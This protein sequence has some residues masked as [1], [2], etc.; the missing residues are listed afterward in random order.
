MEEIVE[1][2]NSSEYDIVKMIILLNKFTY[3]G[4]ET[5]LNYFIYKLLEKKMPEKIFIEIIEY[6]N[7]NN[8]DFTKVKHIEDLIEYIQEEGYINGSTILKT[9]YYIRNFNNEIEKFTY[10]LLG[11][12]CTLQQKV[13][14]L[15]LK[16]DEIDTID[17]N[18]KII[19]LY[20]IMTEA[21]EYILSFDK[22]TSYSKLNIEQQQ[23][24]ENIYKN[25]MINRL[26]LLKKYYGI[27]Y[28]LSINIKI[29]TVSDFIGMSYKDA[30]K[31]YFGCIKIIKKNMN[32]HLRLFHNYMKLR[33]L[34]NET[35]IQDIDQ[36]IDIDNDIDN[37]I[38]DDEDNNEMDVKYPDTI[39]ISDNNDDN[40]LKNVLT[41]FNDTR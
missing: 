26:I 20:K 33:K 9:F 37:D 32:N 1:A 36:D 24:N 19:Q 8:F 23:Q 38:D 10:I 17:F 31:Y 40:L 16:F 7:N 41:R 29:I 14:T 11:S 34:I 27:R 39:I 6:I 4:M 18:N 5:L 13:I 28:L 35:D 12:R 25:E 2:V 21:K 30:N 15:K 22:M 3:D